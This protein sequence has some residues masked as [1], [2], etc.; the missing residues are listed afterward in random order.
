MRLALVAGVGPRTRQ[1]L[2]ERFSTP[3]CVLSA[4]PS[5]LR[6]VPGVGVKLCH[7]IVAARKTID[8]AAEMQLC[9]K[10]AIDVLVEADSDYPQNLRQIIDSPGALFRRGSATGQDPLAVAIVGTRHA[11]R[12]GLRQAD[13]LA[14]GLARAG[15]TVVS[16]LARG[17]DA[18][19]HQGTLRAGGRTVGVL[20]SG[21]LNVYPP[22]H[23]DLAKEIAESGAVYSE[24]P[25]RSHPLSGAF[26]QRNR[27]I[28][29]MSLGVIVVEAPER[30]G[31][32][33]T[34]EHAIQQG[35]EVFA[36]PGPADSRTSRGC[37]RLLRE[38]AKLVEDVDDILEELGPM[39]ARTK[40]PDGTEIRHPAELQLNDQ[41][42]KVLQAIGAQPTN[43]EK[44]VVTSQLPVHRVLSTIS[45]L[46]MRR[47]VRRLSGNQLA[48]I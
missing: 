3:E 5:E 11:T 24:M 7:A 46:E 25:P 33:I 31:A 37:H 4:A 47:L 27:L 17:V 21:L 15:L 45:V 34:A 29:G 2:L 41:E 44:V 16:G 12:Y 14:A 40:R 8:V 9:D 36:V 35:R 6:Q 48:R 39:F 20:G 23:V 32:M 26:P 43:I 30:S 18:A 22:E 28:S 38:G 1:A 10:H 19:A 42:L 13:R